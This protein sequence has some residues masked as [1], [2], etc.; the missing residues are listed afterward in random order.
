MAF[1]SKIYSIKCH[2][3]FL[4]FLFTNYKTSAIIIKQCGRG[5]TADALA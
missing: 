4:K 2:E 5:G 3:Y 1:S